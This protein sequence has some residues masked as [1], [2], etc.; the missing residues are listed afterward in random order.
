MVIGVFKQVTDWPPTVKAIVSPLIGAPPT[1]FVN[2]AVKVNSA[3][4]SVVP[5]DT[6]LIARFRLV[7]VSQLTLTM[8]FDVPGVNK[9][10]L[11]VPPPATWLALM[12]QAYDALLGQLLERAGAFAGTVIVI[13]WPAVTDASDGD[14]LT[15]VIVRSLTVT[16]HGSGAAGGDSTV[17]GPV[18]VNGDGTV[19]TTCLRKCDG[20]L[21]IL[22]VTFKL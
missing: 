5:M 1:V 7:K 22:F 11:P 3:L 16:T 4:V 19:T 15:T 9:Y 6:G 21:K 12:A 20:P 13:P 14:P 17:T 8:G 2:A 18:I 10:A